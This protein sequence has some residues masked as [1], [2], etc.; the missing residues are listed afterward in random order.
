MSRAALLRETKALWADVDFLLKLVQ[1][2]LEATPAMDN[3]LREAEASF[4]RVK[5]RVAG[6]AKR[7]TQG[8]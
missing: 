6:V 3:T 8:P 5:R 1:K 4:E 7:Q 2:Q